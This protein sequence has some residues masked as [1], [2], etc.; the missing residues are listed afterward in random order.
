MT[1]QPDRPQCGIHTDTVC[2]INYIYHYKIEKLE[3][4]VCARVEMWLVDSLDT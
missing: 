1:S 2:S 3:V 4:R